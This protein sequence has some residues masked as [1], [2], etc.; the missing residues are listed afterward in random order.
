MA[1]HQQLLYPNILAP[2]TAVH[3]CE[4]INSEK[5]FGRIGSTFS[6]QHVRGGAQYEVCGNLTGGGR[7]EFVPRLECQRWPRSNLAAGGVFTHGCL[8]ISHSDTSDS[9]ILAILIPPIF[10]YLR[11]L[12][13]TVN[14]P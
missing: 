11:Y 6:C 1:A 4:A 13:S 7:R 2:K 5:M 3:F 9:P 14:L 12:R 10:R 8:P